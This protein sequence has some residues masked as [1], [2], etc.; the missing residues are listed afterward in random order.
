MCFVILRATRAAAQL[1]RPTLVAG[2]IR[3]SQ[4][5]PPCWLISAILLLLARVLALF[6][7]LNLWM[8][9]IVSVRRESMLSEL[10]HTPEPLLAIVESLVSQIPACGTA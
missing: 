5:R 9:F 4:R 7:N 10:V 1:V 2:S 8:S 3:S 6:R